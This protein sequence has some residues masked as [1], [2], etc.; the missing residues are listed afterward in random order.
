MSTPNRARL[1]TLG[2]QPLFIALILFLVGLAAPRP[3]HAFA[4]TLRHGYQQC[5]ACHVDPSGSGA[6]TRYGRGVG[7]EAFHTRWF[8]DTGSA[9]EDEDGARIAGFAFGAV[10]LPK[11]LVLQA[12]ARYMRL[13][14]KVEGAPL[15]KRDIWMQLDFAAALK[16]GHF[17]AFGVLGYAPEG[18]RAAALTAGRTDNLISRTHW[19]GY[20]FAN[21]SLQLRAGRM[22]LPFGLRIPEHTSWVRS[23]TRTNINDHQQY[24]VSLFYGGSALRAEL[25]LVLGNFAISPD[26]YRERGYS[27]FAEWFVAPKLSLGASSLIT[28]RA[29]DSGT[30]KPTYRHAHGIFGRWATPWEPLAI[31]FEGDYVLESPEHANRRKGAVAFLQADAELARGMHVM[32]TGEAQNVGVKGPPLSY[33]AWLSYAW[34]FAPHSDLRVDSVWQRFASKAGDVDALALL[35]QAHVYL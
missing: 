14:Q 25:M 22:N 3:A 7:E 33:G 13:T 8:A 1:Q 4:W 19:L 24:G 2:V 10:K 16:L 30:L 21:D 20:G 11:A 29:L 15:M 34:F 27:G 18:G 6:L 5:N 28:H 23:F 12:D 32:L 17:T 9:D 26:D 35:L 31:L